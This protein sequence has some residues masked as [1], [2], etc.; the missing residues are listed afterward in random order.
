VP[1]IDALERAPLERRVGR[2]HR[3][4]QDRFGGAQVG[5]VGVPAGFDPDSGAVA[6]LHQCGRGCLDQQEVAFFEAVDLG[7]PQAPT[8]HADQRQHLE[9]VALAELGLAEGLADQGRAGKHH[10]L[11]EVT[12]EVISL[13][14]ALRLD[15]LG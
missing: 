6:Q 10:R 13:G 5:V 4:D 8:V 3:F 11:A 7:R 12:V 9:V 14:Q 15:A 2:H 1:K